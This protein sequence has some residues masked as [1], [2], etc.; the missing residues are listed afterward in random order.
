LKVKNKTMGDIT[1]F[2]R[3]KRKEAGNRP[4]VERICDFSEVEQILNSEDRMLQAARCMDC[5][6][7]FCHWG[8]P[9]DNLIPEWNDLLFRGDW[10]GAYKRLNATNNFPEFTGRICPAPCEHACVLNI[11]QDPV[12]IRENEV[13][14]VEKAFSEGYIKPVPPSGRTGKKVAVIGS[15]P[16]GM[17]A[18]DL[19]NKAGHEVTLFE[20]EA[21]AGGLLRYGV[22]DFKLSKTTIDRRLEIMVKEGLT[23]RTNVNIGEDIL[24]QDIV[25]QYDAVCIA[26]GAS[27][28]R[29]LVVEGRDLNGIHFALDFLISQNKINGGESAGMAGP[30]NAK[31]KKVVVIGGGDTGSDCVGTA[32]RQKASGVTQIEILPKPLVIRAPDNPWP[33]YARVMKTS[34]SQEEG[35][36]RIWSLSTVRFIGNEG[37][38]TGVEVEDVEWTEEKS[39]YSMK[40]IA[41]TRRIIEADLVLLALGFINPAQYSMVKDLNVNPDGRYKALT[42][43]GHETGFNKVFAAGDA[44]NGASLVVYAIASGRRA[45]REID[46]FLKLT[47]APLT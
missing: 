15:G 34:T 43:Q 35:C 3:I 5:G 32:I 7:P 9:V 31:D 26:T 18:A 21:R 20:K 45:A 41:G 14:I 17:A 40:I 8:C 47:V 27:Q 46:R 30:V 22:P 16:S 2:I 19:L 25:N 11:Q 1:G 37:N 36:E 13:A 12:T 39:G 4:V 6:V 44:V 24:M 42:G 28:P 33:Y 23:I 29:D 10:K 38:V